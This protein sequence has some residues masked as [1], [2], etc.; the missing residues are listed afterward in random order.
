MARRLIRRTTDLVA[1]GFVIAFSLT[2]GRQV[3]EW[4]REEP[5]EPR[6]SRVTAVDAGRLLA[7][8]QPLLLQFGDLPVEMSQLVVRTDPQNAWNRLQERIQETLAQAGAASDTAGSQFLS[9]KRAASELR[10]LE[11]AASESPV[12]ELEC[13]AVFR[14]ADQFAGAFAVFF[15]PGENRAERVLAGRLL[16][17]GFLLPEGSAGWRLYQ[18][19]RRAQE[20]ER[21]P[22]PVTGPAGSRRL[23][24]AGSATSGTLV[25]FR[26]PGSLTDWRRHFDNWYVRNGWIPAVDWVQTDSTAGAR[27][28]H[29]LAATE[30][31][32]EVRLVKNE[33]GEVTGLLQFPGAGE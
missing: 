19:Q 25:A 31:L 8:D 17:W 6:S 1:I 18:F 4:W 23:L 32:A 20:A 28:R 10:V 16:A 9:Q 21:E 24:S 15:G 29:G 11:L 3:I 27:Y 26:G 7:P 13:G 22:V 2:T 14:F 12:A 5:A 30:R 33:S